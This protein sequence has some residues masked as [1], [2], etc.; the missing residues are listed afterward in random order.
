VLVYAL[1]HVIYVSLYV[2]VWHV[3]DV[4]CMWMWIRT[5]AVMTI[6]VSGDYTLYRVVALV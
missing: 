4:C 3:S 6:Y 2:C 1:V 5:T